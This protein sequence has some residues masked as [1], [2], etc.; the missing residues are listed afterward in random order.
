MLLAVRA[1]AVAMVGDFSEYVDIAGL[2]MRHNS[3]HASTV[4][5]SLFACIVQMEGLHDTMLKTWFAM[6][7]NCIGRY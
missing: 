2:Y 1:T 4:P 3:L 6:G 7:A 5:F